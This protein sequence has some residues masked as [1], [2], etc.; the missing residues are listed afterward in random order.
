MFTTRPKEMFNEWGKTQSWGSCRMLPTQNA[1][2][3]S[4]HADF[5]GK[6][7]TELRKFARW[8]ERAA[9]YLEE[10]HGRA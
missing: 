1:A 6:S 2:H 5:D 7:A 8:M 10:N 4:I 9:K 3:I